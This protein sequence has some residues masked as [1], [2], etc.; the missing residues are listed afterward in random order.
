MKIPRG[1]LYKAL[2]IHNIMLAYTYLNRRKFD[3][4]KKIKTADWD[5]H[6]MVENL[7]TNTSI[8][9]KSLPQ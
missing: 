5:N 3:T 7:I 4:S 6:K 8:Y 2:R 1:D 9:R